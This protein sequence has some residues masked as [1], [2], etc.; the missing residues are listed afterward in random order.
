MEL[1]FITLAHGQTEKPAGLRPGPRPG[2]APAWLGRCGTPAPPQSTD[3]SAGEC[4]AARGGV[5][6][7]RGSARGTPKQALSANG[8]PVLMQISL[9]LLRCRQDRTAADAGCRP[10]SRDRS[11]GP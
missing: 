7:G 6:A 11:V 8:V 2:A 5:S 3:E 9:F 10:P 4:P 1:G